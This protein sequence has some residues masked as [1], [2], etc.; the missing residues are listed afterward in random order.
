MTPPWPG[1]RWPASLAPNW[2]LIQDSKQIAELRRDGQQQGDGGD[3][4]PVERSEITGDGDR[5]DHG[6]EHAGNRAGPG[7]VR[8]DGGHE[9]GAA[10]GAAGEKSENVGRP[11]DRKQQHH[12]EKPVTLVIA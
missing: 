10:E 11:D 3:H 9:L 7:L 12:R 6:A 1:M 8:A 4:D 5:H 2:R